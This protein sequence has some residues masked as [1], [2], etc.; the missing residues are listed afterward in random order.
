MKFILTQELGRLSKWLRILGYDSVYFTQEN[1]GTLIVEALKDERI[2][3][4]RHQKIPLGRGV[5]ILNIK[6]DSVKEQLQQVL[7]ELQLKLDEDILFSRCIICNTLLEE[8]E[9]EEIKDKVPEY[10]FK[11]QRNFT[12]CPKCQRIYWQ[13]THWGN[14]KKTL[15]EITQ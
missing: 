13:G 15:E 7:A 11:T 6:S 10:V 1:M 3:L 9:K 12:V 4:T 5:K 8:I 14:V 2:I